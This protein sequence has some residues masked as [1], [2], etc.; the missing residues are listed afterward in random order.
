MLHLNSLVIGYDKTHPISKKINSSFGPYVYAIL[1]KSGCGK[2]TM[3]KTIAGLIKPI[4]GSVITTP[5]ESIYMMHQHYSNFPWKTC[6]EN[7]LMVKSIKGK[8]TDEDRRS[9][10]SILKQVGLEGYENEYPSKLSGGMNQRLALARTLFA[11]PKILLMDEPLSA[12]DDKTRAAMQQ[13]IINNHN[14][15]KSTVLLVTHSED[16][17][18]KIA[19]YIIR[20]ED[21][22]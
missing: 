19:D 17:A 15:I 4:S 9:A 6:I 7:V 18:K 22:I 13:L 20:M 12:L 8:V 10:A 5:V 16:E 14:N 21:L 1:G 11:Q 3:L 2:T